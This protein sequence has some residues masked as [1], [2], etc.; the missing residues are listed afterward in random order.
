MKETHN[1][2]IN[3]SEISDN[4]AF[5]LRNLALEIEE[6]NKENRRLDPYTE[7]KLL[8]ASNILDSIDLINQ[9]EMFS[10]NAVATEISSHSS[11]L[12]PKDVY[13]QNAKIASDD[14]EYAIGSI[15][16]IHGKARL[17]LSNG[18]DVRIALAQEYKKTSDKDANR[19]TSTELIFLDSNDKIKNSIKIDV[20]SQAVIDYFSQQKEQNVQEATMDMIADYL[21]EEYNMSISYEQRNFLR[22]QWNQASVQ[23]FTGVFHLDGNIPG[24]ER[25]LDRNKNICSFVFKENQLQSLKFS[26]SFSQTDSER[27]IIEGAPQSVAQVTADISHLVGLSSTNNPELR[28]EDWLPKN[29]AKVTLNYKSAGNLSTRTINQDII[30]AIGPNAVTMSNSPK[31]TELDKIRDNFTNFLSSFSTKNSSK[32]D[33]ATGSNILRGR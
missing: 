15:G 21:Q 28:T 24:A 10:N 7:L 6:E 22:T 11:I 5:N 29:K 32:A 31:I 23:G 27:N 20:L 18:E 14:P 25:L 2:E 30:N 26:Q 9:C 8:S 3:F 12:R 1:I 33:Q 17:L 16:G 13:M 19:I 4:A